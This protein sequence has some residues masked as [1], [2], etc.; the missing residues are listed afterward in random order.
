M[1]LRRVLSILALALLA[2]LAS[3]FAQGGSIIRGHIR[4]AESGTPLAG[5]QVRVDGTTIG[6]LSGADGS[7]TIVGAPPGSRFVS[8]RRVGYAPM[9]AAVTVG[10]ST[11]STQDFSLHKVATT[12][13]EVV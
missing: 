8:A 11:S 9:R 1:S 2:P 5:V 6:A 3:A 4:D 13:N 10:A 12:L 7:Y